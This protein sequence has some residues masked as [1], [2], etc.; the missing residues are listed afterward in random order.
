MQRWV[1]FA[2]IWA[3]ACLNLLYADSARIS[4]V[5]PGPYLEVTFDTGA[6]GLYAVPQSGW[7]G[8]LILYAHGYAAVTEPL[9]FY[10]LQF[11]DVYAPDLLQQAGFAFAA[12]TFRSNGLSVLDG[13][14]D[15]MDLLRNFRDVT[16]QR[17][18]RVFLNGA[19]QG[20]LVVLKTLER[21]PRYFAGGMAL[22]GPI[23]SFEGQLN[24]IH[25][26]RMLFDLYFPGVLPGSTISV[27]TSMPG[28]WLDIHLPGIMHAID[29]DPARAMELLDVAGVAYD[30]E[31]FDTVRE[32]YR[33]ILWYHTFGTEDAVQRI[34]GQV[35]ENRFRRY[36][37][38]VDDRALNVSAPRYRG[39]PG[40]R[41][42]LLPYE[43][44]GRIAKPLVLM[45]T[46]GD[47]L[48]PFRHLIRYYAKSRQAGTTP[49]FL[50]V[51]GYG[52]CE[53]APEDLVYGLTW[54]LYLAR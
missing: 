11:G 21:Y 6:R 17:P 22:C 33:V 19:S 44:S 24:Y 7:N 40:I 37:G 9:D 42:A 43:T 34:G 13:V 39:D 32:A 47:E 15:M 53:F 5:V 29:A 27:P 46:T 41:R 10:N 48:V 20:A 31:S 8:D 3:A 23:G 52:H 12:T 35:Y 2:G 51:R 4:P 18:R 16:G 1:L 54:L 38:S 25:D 26:V 14:E 45:H 30:P 36:R 28:N 49:V 50:P